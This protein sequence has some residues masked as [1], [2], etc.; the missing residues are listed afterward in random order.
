MCTSNFTSPYV[1][2]K[3]LSIGLV[4]ICSCAGPPA[5]AEHSQLHDWRQPAQVSGVPGDDSH[6]R[7]GGR[8]ERTFQGGCIPSIGMETAV[9]SGFDQ[10]PSIC[11]LSCTLTYSKPMALASVTCIIHSS[12]AR[13]WRHGQ[14]PRCN[15]EQ[16]E[17]TFQEDLH[18]GHCARDPSPIP[19]HRPEAGPLPARARLFL[20]QAL[21]AFIIIACLH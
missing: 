20:G 4:T 1:G 18:A 19:L 5:A 7:Q 8:R 21:W 14:N 16:S 15:Y 2:C 9:D 17:S 13:L 3:F 11:L 6:D 12:H 10:L